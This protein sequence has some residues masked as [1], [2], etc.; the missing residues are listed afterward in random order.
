[1]SKSRQTTSR[2]REYFIINIIN[3]I[4]KVLASF[5]QAYEVRRS[6]LINYR[7]NKF[8]K[9]WT[10]GSDLRWRIIELNY[11]FMPW[12]KIY[13]TA[14]YMFFFSILI[15]S[16]AFS[17]STILLRIS[18]AVKKKTHTLDTPFITNLETYISACMLAFD[19][20]LLDLLLHLA[21]FLFFLLSFLP[22]SLFFLSFPS[23]VFQDY[24]LYL[25]IILMLLF[26]LYCLLWFFF[27]FST[28]FLFV[29][30]YPVPFSL[31][32]F[33]YVVCNH[34]LVCKTFLGQLMPLVCITTSCFQ[35][36]KSYSVRF[37]YTHTLL[38]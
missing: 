29:L 13:M 30:P 37:H 36:K 5:I 14:M 23:F 12:K 2:A 38:A 10:D 25:F 11:H 8:Q 18:P 6:N 31:I 21:C 33:L 28:I 24:L 22:T 35:P 20:F 27:L 16:E 9:S 19:A 15:D 32:W 26:C 34:T 7:Y 1:M 17:S 4:P 3:N